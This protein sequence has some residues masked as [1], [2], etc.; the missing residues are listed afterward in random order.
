MKVR[1]SRLRK[2]ARHLRSGKLGHKEFNFG[3]WNDASGP[4]CG[5]AGCAIG[6]C[7]ILFREDWRFDSI[8]FPV[9]RKRTKEA[10]REPEAAEDTESAAMQYFGLRLYEVCRLFTPS[11][12]LPV[13]STAAEVADAIDKFCDEVKR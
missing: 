7:P 11:P 12:E 2:L 5:T 13:Y 4:R 8:G 1:V 6:E 3:V 10:K 9:L